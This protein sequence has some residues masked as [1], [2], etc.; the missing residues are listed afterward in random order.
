MRR[1]A[2]LMRWMLALLVAGAAFPWLTAGGGIAAAEPQPIIID[3]FSTPQAEI[4]IFQPGTRSA[5]AVTSAGILGGARV[6]SAEHT[7]TTTAN[8]FF[9]V[10]VKDGYYYSS[11]Q[12]NGQ[13]NGAI[14]WHG[15]TNTE[16]LNPTGLGGVDLTGGGYWNGFAIVAGRNGMQNNVV[17]TV[18]T[19]GTHYSTTSFM[20]PFT[21]VNSEPHDTVRLPFAGFTAAGPD[22][23]ADFSNVGAITITFS[24]GSG[25]GPYVSL[26]ETDRM[27]V[28]PDVNAG[29]PYSGSVRQP[30]SIAGQVDDRDDDTITTTWDWEAVGGTSGTCTVAN[31]SAL[32]TTV[33]CTKVGTYRLTLTASDGVNLPVTAEASLTINQGSPTITW[34]PPTWITYSPLSATVLGATASVA[35]SFSYQV[36]GGD[37]RWAL[38]QRNGP[39]RHCARCGHLHADGDV[40]TG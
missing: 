22:G 24:E 18:Y 11:R 25:Y 29:G 12:I 4:A 14:W 10:G 32:T 28:P 16:T 34:D 38:G 23:G 6:I 2:I 26:F 5:S 30:V 37:G 19:D 27:N 31:A 20:P 36:Q 39:D 8:S 15:N 21:P 7:G 35:G 13:G 9:W 17:V 1:L 40:Y 33:T 3:D